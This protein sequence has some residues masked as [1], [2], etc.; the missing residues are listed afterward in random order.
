MNRFVRL[1]LFCVATTLGLTAFG[2]NEV[3]EAA[4]KIL[5][6]ALDQEILFSLETEE[7]CTQGGFGT[8]NVLVPDWIRGEPANYE[9]FKSTIYNLILAW[10]IVGA[11]RCPVHFIFPSSRTRHPPLGAYVTHT[12]I[13]SDSSASL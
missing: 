1:T 9:L 2:Q 12:L 5:Q 11:G 10:N 6:D 3:V 8:F 13:F 7:A 4:E